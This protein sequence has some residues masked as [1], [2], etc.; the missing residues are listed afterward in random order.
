MR[1]LI[2]LEQREELQFWQAAHPHQVLVWSVRPYVTLSSGRRSFFGPGQQFE[3]LPAAHKYAT[4]QARRYAA[5]AREA[6]IA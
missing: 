1:W 5:R 2:L 6:A 3:S 4:G